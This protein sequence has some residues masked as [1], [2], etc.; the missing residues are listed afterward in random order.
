MFNLNSSQ[1]YKVFFKECLLHLFVKS[2]ISS[3][4]NIDK[5]VEY[6]SFGVFLELL[7][8]IDCLKHVE[9]PILVVFSDEA[10]LQS[11]VQSFHQLPA[12]G[13]LVRRGD[14]RILFIHRLGKW[15]LPKGKIETGESVQEAALREVEEECSIS[16]LTIIRLLPSTYHIYRSPWL[17]AG[18]NWVWK[19]TCWFEMFYDGS[20]LPSPQI[21][22]DIT[23]IRWFAPDELSEMLA[24]T[25]GNI[26]WLVRSYCP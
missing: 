18:D 13:G 3:S 21:E 10:T 4:H 15:D 9:E 25:F 6:Q 23:E 8:A 22:E 2:Q 5:V 20:E 7:K 14:G 16:H 12:A 1:M 24:N 11:A 26:A 17:P 19:E